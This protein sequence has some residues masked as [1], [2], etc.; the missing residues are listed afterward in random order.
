MGDQQLEHADVQNPKGQ[1]QSQVGNKEA[2]TFVI[3]AMRPAQAPD[4]RRP[5][6]Y[7][8]FPSPDSTARHTT[9]R[10]QNWLVAFLSGFVR[11]TS[12]TWPPSLVASAPCCVEGVVSLMGETISMPMRLGALLPVYG[13]GTLAFHGSIG[14]DLTIATPRFPLDRTLACPWLFRG[15]DGCIMRHNTHVRRPGTPG[16]CSELHPP[17]CSSCNHAERFQKG[18]RFCEDI[19]SE[20]ESLVSS[21][22][23][24]IGPSEIFQVPS[25]PYS[26]KG[27]VIWD[28]VLFSLPDQRPPSRY[29]RGWRNT[30]ATGVASAPG[31]LKEP[32]QW[33]E[34]AGQSV[35]V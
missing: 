24:T 6:A 21:D 32:G 5:S 10:M 19:G 34:C 35:A 17:A 15:R 28:Q 2:Q 33:L 16:T 26:L 29:T 12:H 13:A 1:P 11:H 9:S 3:S 7:P 18:L 31:N 23:W 22:P 8:G 25:F 30:G 27:R 20:P 4:A 14:G